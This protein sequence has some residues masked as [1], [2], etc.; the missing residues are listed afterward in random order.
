MLK[1]A[2]LTSRIRS[3]LMTQTIPAA[4]QPSTLTARRRTLGLVGVS[5]AHAVNH[6]YGALLPL[7]YP[8]LL[9]QF[10]FSYTVLGAVIALSNLS[11]GLMQ[12]VFGY[13]NR[14]VSARSLIGWENVVLGGCVA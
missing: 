14:R 12:A 13:I 5:A 8:L 6:M 4:L 10:H 1:L 7:V 3:D 2:H 11:G 9:V